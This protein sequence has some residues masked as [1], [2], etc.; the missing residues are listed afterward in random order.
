VLDIKILGM[1]V[2]GMVLKIGFVLAGGGGKGAYQIG[3]IKNRDKCSC[4]TLVLNKRSQE[5]FLT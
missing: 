3:V 4:D 5:L 2:G 1:T